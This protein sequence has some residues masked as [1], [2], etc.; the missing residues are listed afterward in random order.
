MSER[1]IPF[2]YF[3]K[4]SVSPVGDI[5][6]MLNYWDFEKWRRGRARHNLNYYASDFNQPDHISGALLTNHQQYQFYR[7]EGLLGRDLADIESELEWGRHTLALPFDVLPLKLDDGDFPSDPEN[8]C[9]LISLKDQYLAERNRFMAM[10]DALFALAVI[11]PDP[12]SELLQTKTPITSVKEEDIEIF[13]RE[14]AYEVEE[15]L[16]YLPRCLDAYDPATSGDFITDYTRV[17]Q[18][19]FAIAFFENTMFAAI[20]AVVGDISS[21]LTSSDADHTVHLINQLIG[22]N[23][24]RRLVRNSNIAALLTSMQN[25][26]WRKAALA[27][28]KRFRNFVTKQPGLEHMAGVPAGGTLVLAYEDVAGVPTVQLDFALPNPVACCCVETPVCANPDIHNFAPLTWPVGALASDFVVEINVLDGAFDVD[29]E[30]LRIE[31]SDAAT[32]LGGQVAIVDATAGIFSVTYTASDIEFGENEALIIDTFS[33]LI[34]SEPEG[35]TPSEP[36]QLGINRAFIVHHNPEF[37]EALEPAEDSSVTNDDD[38]GTT[39]T[40]GGSGW[41]VSIGRPRETYFGKKATDKDPNNAFSSWG[42]FKTSSTQ[43]L[44]NSVMNEATNNFGSGLDAVLCAIQDDDLKLDQ[45]TLDI[46]EDA[47]RFHEEIQCIPKHN[48]KLI[49]FYLGKLDE[50]HATEVNRILGGFH[51]SVL[52]AQN[53]LSVLDA[54]GEVDTPREDLEAQIRTSGAMYQTSLNY[55]VELAKNST[56]SLDHRNAFHATL[57]STVPVQLTQVNDLAAAA[58][59]AA[60]A[61][62]TPAIATLN[63]EI[64][65]VTGLQLK[66]IEQDAVYANQN[67]GLLNIVD[68]WGAVYLTPG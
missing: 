6:P 44:W 49:R 16:K 68:G 60:P 67:A 26:L 43:R 47:K 53:K 64:V 34:T 17:M 10:F 5:D 65:E 18:K 22:I 20:S 63:S 9:S 51:K 61:G 30:D 56:D 50:D 32:V 12:N 2:Y 8:D 29:L 41:S 13:R 40:S 7:V 14:M 28:T 15:L 48:G 42:S 59:A 23:E 25:Y 55:T 24:L 38:T 1:S 58:T 37:F 45:P 39:S 57:N 35:S 52:D 19:V 27:E 36:N 21:I 4:A 31:G 66:T 62:T 11:H 54:G 46:V 33:W 3:N